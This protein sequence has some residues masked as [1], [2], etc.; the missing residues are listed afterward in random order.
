MASL[1]AEN[2]FKTNLK[3]LLEMAVINNLSFKKKRKV[4][5]LL[6]TE[7]EKVYRDRRDKAR[8]KKVGLEIQ[9]ETLIVQLRL[10]MF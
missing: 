2:K 7:I 4:W 1:M 10:Q 3:I 8:N 6:V 9:A 5:A